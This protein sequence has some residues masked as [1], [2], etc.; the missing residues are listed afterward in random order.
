MGILDGKVVLV[1]GAGRGIGAACAEA[2][3]ACGACVVVNDIDLQ[4]ATQTA[5]RIEM[6]GGR[7]LALQGDVSSWAGAAALVT[8]TVAHFGA[9]DGLVNNAALFAMDRIDEVREE[10]IDALLAVNIKGVLALTR[11]AAAHMI[12]QGQG[13]IVNVCSGA[14]MGTARL[15]LYGATKGA[16]ASMTYA[17]AIDFAG[18]G[19]RANISCPRAD[20]AMTAHMLKYSEAHGKT[21]KDDTRSPRPATADNAPLICWLLS[22]LARDVNGQAFET[23][24][25][26][27]SLV[28]HPQLS[29]PAVQAASW[30]PEE[31]GRTVSR[32]FAPHFSPNGIAVRDRE[33]GA[34]TLR[35]AGLMAGSPGA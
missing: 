19:V 16:V 25:E 26:F 6:A 21:P 23:D 3:A 10:D 22:D 11:F 17:A 15:A 32:D 8:S 34:V 27:L 2:A 35:R 12:G 7:A 18:T 30:T 24:G 28:N 33:S 4:A 29:G 13:S 5:G 20:T 14:M 1:T 31:I 9:L